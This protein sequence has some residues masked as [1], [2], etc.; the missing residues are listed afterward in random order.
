MNDRILFHEDHKKE[1]QSVVFMIFLLSVVV[2]ILLITILI[3]FNDPEFFLGVYIQILIVVSVCLII[4]IIYS[5]KSFALN[6]AFTI[7]RQ[8]FKCTRTIKKFN[9]NS[10]DAQKF[11]CYR[12]VNLS[13]FGYTSIEIT[14][15]LPTSDSNETKLIC[16]TKKPLELTQALDIILADN[17]Q[18]K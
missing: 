16:F 8:E 2:I 10:F 13:K 17:A 11:K 4:L 3:N 15:E 7:T 5:V 9:T 6:C 14:F 18:R 1:K 12:L